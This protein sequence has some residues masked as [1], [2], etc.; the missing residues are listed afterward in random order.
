MF[1][2]HRSIDVIKIEYRTFYFEGHALFTTELPPLSSAGIVRAA[3]GREGEGG[4]GGRATAGPGRRFIKAF[5][6]ATM[7]LV[8][9]IRE[10]KKGILRVLLCAVLMK[11][12][13]KNAY[14]ETSGGKSSPD[15]LQF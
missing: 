14:G 11:N 4:R 5:D 2:T 12:A 3:A 15:S 1:K 13:V 10:K 8:I 7:E 9:K 6:V